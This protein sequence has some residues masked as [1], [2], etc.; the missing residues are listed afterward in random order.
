MNSFGTLVKEFFPD[1]MTTGNERYLFIGDLAPGFY[2]VKI[3]EE[4]ETFLSKL[5]IE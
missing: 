4:K 2:L 3:Q 1:N 5:V